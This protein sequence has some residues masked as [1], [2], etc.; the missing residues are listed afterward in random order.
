ML[1]DSLGLSVHPEKSVLEPTQKIVF[2]G[3]ILCSVT[4]TVRLTSE[5]C[6]DINDLCR[7]ILSE[8]KIEIR[9]FAKLIGKLVA[10]EPGVEYTP[11]YFKTT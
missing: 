1:M 7:R 5:R 4:M 6:Q 2:L 8:N 3:F 9:L 10:S 11:L